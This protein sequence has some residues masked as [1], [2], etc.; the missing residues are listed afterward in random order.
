MSWD[1]PSADT[2][3]WD[4]APATD[5]GASWDKPSADATNGWDNSAGNGWD[6]SAAAASAPA[7]PAAP[8]E[9]DER[10]KKW[11]PR[12]GIFNPGEVREGEAKWLASAARWEEGVENPELEKE[13]FEENR[14]NTGIN[15][16]DVANI[17]VTV[18]GE[19]VPERWHSFDDL[20][21]HPILR[22]NIELL[23]YKTP[24]PIQKFSIPI[25]LEGRDLMASAQTG[26]GKTA[27]YVI[28]I[29]QKFLTKGKEKLR[30]NEPDLLPGRRQTATPFAVILAPT[31]ELACQIFDDVRKFAY[32]TWVRPAVVYGGANGRVLLDELDKG[33]D[34]LIGTP[35]RIQDFASRGKISFRKVKYL[36]MDEA[37]RMLDLGF[38]PAIRRLIQAED[39][40]QDES[41]Q[42]AMFSATYPLPIRR[43]ARDFL[44]DCLLVTVG[45]VGKIPKDLHQ[46]IEFVEDHE[47]R[48]KLLELLYNQEAGLTLIFVATKRAA[49]S[50]DDFLYTKGFPI[51]SIHGD[52]SQREREDAISAFRANKTPILIATDVAAR[53]LDIPN[54]VHVIN[55]DLP[56][57]LDDYIHR[58]GRTARAGNKGFATSFYNESNA[59]IAKDLCN[60]LEDAEIPEFLREYAPKPEEK[61]AAVDELKEQDMEGELP[62][63]Y[64]PLG[65]KP[66]EGG[67][68]WGSGAN[69][70]WGAP[71]Q[72]ATN[73]GTDA[74]GTDTAA[75]G[76]DDWT[77]A[78][79][80]APA[81]KADDDWDTPAAAADGEESLG[82]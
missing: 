69:D 2:A 21:L 73:G 38:E 14:V 16:D 63:G 19:D 27:A 59:E 64:N 24:T 80:G 67:D 76:G 20:A 18:R 17:D 37:D 42:T 47:K 30:G 1:S 55:Y 49:D 66:A 15:F 57:T 72:G 79:N 71:E 31:R 39:M 13:L 44:G 5:A 8:Q 68:A 43:L 41:R 77:S 78:A 70:A 26:S 46:K 28:P 53:G 33:C 32:R 50:L 48:D 60:I 52:R 54:V 4:D 23:K 82:W 9:P 65:A 7:A 35:G 62:P 58:I 45:R 61:E 56:T 36:I 40:P 25:L 10:V 6:N 81:A 3:T 12:E 74:W 11:G 29:L 22:K 75:G 34:V 51:T